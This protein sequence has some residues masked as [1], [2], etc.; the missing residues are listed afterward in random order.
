MYAEQCCS[1]GCSR[2]T[3]AW[4]NLQTGLGHTNLHLPP[5]CQVAARLVQDQKFKEGGTLI[6]NSKLR[7]VSVDMAPPERPCLL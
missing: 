5:R 4:P 6:D 2:R 3:G 1:Q 7:R